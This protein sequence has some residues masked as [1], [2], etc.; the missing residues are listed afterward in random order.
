MDQGELRPVDKAE[1]ATPIVVVPKVMVHGIHTCG[2]FKDTINPV[3]FPQVFPLLT[4]EEMFSA[5]AN[6]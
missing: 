3:I 2:D 1:W 4:S 5:L 6:G